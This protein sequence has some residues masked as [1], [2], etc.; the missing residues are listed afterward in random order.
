MV[1]QNYCVFSKVVVHLKHLIYISKAS[2]CVNYLA[3]ATK[4]KKKSFSYCLRLMRNESHTQ[5][6]FILLFIRTLYCIVQKCIFFL[7]LTISLR[8]T[9]TVLVSETDT[10]SLCRFIT[11][12]LTLLHM[13]WTTNKLF[14]DLNS[15]FWKMFFPFKNWAKMIEK[16]TNHSFLPCVCVHVSVSMCGVILYSTNITVEYQARVF[17]FMLLRILSWSVCVSIIYLVPYFC[18][19]F[20]SCLTCVTLL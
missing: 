9:S 15:V 18:C 14:R 17:C 10:N 1:H 6:C 12:V 8:V 11:I 13:L 4:I 5:I 3:S 2:F 7:S 16:N 20:I 19:C